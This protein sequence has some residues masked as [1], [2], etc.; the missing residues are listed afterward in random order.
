MG[1]GLSIC[2]SIIEAHAGRLWASR[3]RRMA[4]LFD[5]PCR[6]RPNFNSLAARSRIAKSRGA[7]SSRN[8]SHQPVSRV[9]AIVASSAFGGRG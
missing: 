1:I 8:A 4:R 2:R 7:L 5:S 3:V 9:T 6:L